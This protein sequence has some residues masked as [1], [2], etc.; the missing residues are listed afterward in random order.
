MISL[1]QLLYS[2]WPV[3][4]VAALF[5][6]PNRRQPFSARLRT[7]LT[8]SLLAWIAWAVC[9]LVLLYSAAPGLGLIPEPA[10]TILFLLTGAALLA[11][12][13][14]PRLLSYLRIQQALWTA[15]DV[16]V[17]RLLSPTDFESLVGAYFRQYGYRVEHTGRTGDHGVDLVVTPSSGEKW[18]V[19]CKRWK[20]VLGEPLVRDLY[21]TMFHENANR[22]FLI[23][24]GTF[25]PAALTW[26]QGKPI[27][28]YDGQGL[29]RLVKR[30]QNWRNPQ[31]SNPR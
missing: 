25:S 28:L 30:V 19:Q 8:G 2:L 22:A 11:Y 26:V 23:T 27:T 12:C 17:L 18:V 13:A 15:Q 6:Q 16:E 20:G 3:I 31:K 5:V 4:F 24:T 21:G 7:R 9:G 14:G 1:F 29:V 10:N